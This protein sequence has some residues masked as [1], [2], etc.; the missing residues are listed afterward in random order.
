MAD[1]ASFLVLPWTELGQR[2]L[3]CTAALAVLDFGLCYRTK[4]AIVLRPPGVQ[5]NAAIFFFSFFLFCVFSLLSDES[6]ARY[7]FLHALWNFCIVLTVLPGCYLTLR[8]P[9]SFVLTK[10]PAN[11]WCVI[12]VAALHLWHCIAYSGL[13]CKLPR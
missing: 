4:G 8:D 9:F 3:I 6:T 10:D 1:Q 12:M 13:T 11:H 7:F 2:F 5:K